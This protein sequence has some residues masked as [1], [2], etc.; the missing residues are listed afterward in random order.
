MWIARVVTLVLVAAS[1]NGLAASLR[2][3]D[4]VVTAGFITLHIE[5]T[6]PPLQQ[7]TQLSIQRLSEPYSLSLSLK[8]TQ[9]AV[10]ISGLADGDYLATLDNPSANSAQTS[11]SFTVKHHQL[12]LALALFVLGLCLFVLLVGMIVVGN[13]QAHDKE[14][15]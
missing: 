7:S 5:R 13:K 11:V 14:S 3:S 1:F 10:T 8:P 12:T 15:V 6:G 9:Q 4:E 2:V